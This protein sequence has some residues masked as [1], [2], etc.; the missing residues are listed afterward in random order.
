M[1]ESLDFPDRRD[2]LDTGS[3]AELVLDCRELHLPEFA[4]LSWIP[5][6]VTVTVPDDAAELLVGLGDYGS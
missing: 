5:E 3:V 2:G 4:P 6:H 1:T